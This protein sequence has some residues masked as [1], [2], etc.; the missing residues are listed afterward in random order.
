[1]IRTELKGNT[2]FIMIETDA[3]NQLINTVMTTVKQEMKRQPEDWIDENE[4]KAIL[5]VSSKSTIQRFRTEN[6]IRYAMV[7]NKNIMY[8]RKSILKYLE[9]KS[10]M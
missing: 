7:T 6:R 3:L 1:M 8:S 4:T 2:Q 9:T 10:N 5:G